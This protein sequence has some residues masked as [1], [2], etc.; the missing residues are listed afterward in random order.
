MPAGSRTTWRLPAAILFVI[1]SSAVTALAQ[2]PRAKAKPPAAAQ[3]IPAE[4]AA[5]WSIKPLQLQN[6]RR[7]VLDPGH[8]GDNLGTVGVMGLREKSLM[9]DYARSIATYVRTHS[10][11]EV[12]L[13]RDRD[14]AVEL[15]AR[16]RLANDLKGDAFISLHANAHE[17]GEAQGMEVFF[18]AADSSVASTRQLIERE[19]GIRPTDAT[20]ALPW[21]VG[22]ILNDLGHNTAHARSEVLAAGLAAALQKVRPGVRFRGVKQA[23]FGVLKEASMPAVVLEVGYLTHAQEAHDLLEPKTPLQ[24][25]QAILMAL[26]TLDLQ[27]ATETRPRAPAATKKASPALT[28]KAS[29]V[30]AMR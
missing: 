23:P 17:L 20:A 14:A 3:R 19:E 30:S 18:L 21:S 24:F 11:V 4:D 28:R 10:N 5:S 26:Q 8:G 29:K 12:L 7:L 6:I 22:G 9:L 16:P 15:R 25:G 27:M 2:P 1:A 13:T